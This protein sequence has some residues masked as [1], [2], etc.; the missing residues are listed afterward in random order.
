MVNGASQHRSL[1]G[2]AHDLLS[3][4]SLETRF[5]SIF[6]QDLEEGLAGFTGRRWSSYNIGIPFPF[7][8]I[9]FFRDERFRLLG[10]EAWN[11]SEAWEG[12]GRELVG[13]NV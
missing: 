1:L 10:H 8:G 4:H 6:T 7:P 9:A 5:F 11:K 13:H 12:N 2:N 3:I